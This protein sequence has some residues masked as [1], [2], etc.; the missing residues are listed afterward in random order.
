MMLARTLTTLSHF[1]SSLS[2]PEMENRQAVFYAAED[3]QLDWKVKSH[4][5]DVYHC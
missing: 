5:L 2:P 4:R 1:V 3:A